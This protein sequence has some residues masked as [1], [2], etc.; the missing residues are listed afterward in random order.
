M[1]SHLGQPPRYS[2]RKKTAFIDQHAVDTRDHRPTAQHRKSQAQND[3]VLQSVVEKHRRGATCA[4][5]QSL[6][7]LGSSEFPLAPDTLNEYRSARCISSVRGLADDLCKNGVCSRVL[8]DGENK[9][10]EELNF[11][12]K[13][14]LCF[15]RDKKLGCAPTL[16]HSMAIHISRVQIIHP[17]HNFMEPTAE[18]RQ[19]FSLWGGDWNHTNVAAMRAKSDRNIELTCNRTIKLTG[20]VVNVLFVFVFT[21]YW[22]KTHSAR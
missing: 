7:G 9:F 8:S 3:E 14:F 18:F 16:A 10:F 21:H 22:R 19:T 11:D 6:M 12:A 15:D 5:P 1:D 20:D 2:P 17:P 13:D 4:D